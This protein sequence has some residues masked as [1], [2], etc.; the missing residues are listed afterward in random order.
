M[1]IGIIG[2]GAMGC[3]FGG[4]LSR[5]ADVTLLTHRKQQAQAIKE[6]GLSIQTDQGPVACRTLRAVFAADAAET[7]DLLVIFVKAFQTRDAIEGIRSCIGPKTVLLTL[8]NGIG[9]GQTLQQ[10]FSPEQ[11]LVGT[12]TINSQ[13]LSDIAV[14]QHGGMGIT[15]IGSLCGK[16][17][18]AE[19]IADYFS[20]CGF[21]AEASMNIDGL[22][23][24]K[25]FINLTINPLTALFD[26]PIGMV[27]QCEDAWALGRQEIAEAVQ[28]ANAS[29]QS[30]S[31]DEICD[32]VYQVLYGAREG[33]T[34]MRTDIHA[35]RQTEIAYLNG[36]VAELG[37]Q[38]GIPTPYNAMMTQLIRTLEFTTQ[39]G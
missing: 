34:S 35:G 10:L 25:A 12:S 6:K 11:I 33:T 17:A 14:R 37:K 15:T 38:Y 26:R 5:Q 8:Q 18:L 4:Y 20:S 22:I 31:Y 9:N 23:W 39:H 21:C 2:T 7:F 16:T 24:K 28:V 30:F 32:Y 19:Q 29:G 27:A 3:L 36:A 1:K 13:R